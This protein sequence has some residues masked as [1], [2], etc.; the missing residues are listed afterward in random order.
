[1]RRGA[2][3]FCACQ[4]ERNVCMRGR[5]V[6]HCASHFVCV[7][8]VGVGVCVLHFIVSGINTVINFARE[9]TDRFE[10]RSI[11]SIR[12]LFVHFQLIS[13]SFSDV[14]EIY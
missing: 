6:R 8:A 9:R 10:N 12:V 13:V 2:Y 4:A 3:A 7:S 11:H 14:F 1:M 5:G